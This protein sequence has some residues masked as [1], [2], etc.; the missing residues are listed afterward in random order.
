MDRLWRTR[1]VHTAGCYEAICKHDLEL[2]G[3]S[4]MGLNTLRHSKLCVTSLL[5]MISDVVL[6]KYLAIVLT[7]HDFLF[8]D[9]RSVI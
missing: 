1:W 7:V 5:L 8:V 9:E 2:H 4:L 3:A 6:Y